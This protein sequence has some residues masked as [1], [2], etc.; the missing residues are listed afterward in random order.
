MWQW[1]PAQYRKINHR[2]HKDDLHFC[3]CGSIQV[4]I[5]CAFIEQLF[6]VLAKVTGSRFMKN[7]VC[8]GV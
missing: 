4:N 3:A 6:Q 8:F 7:G 2:L 1:L 5:F